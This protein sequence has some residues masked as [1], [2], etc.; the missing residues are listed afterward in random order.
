MLRKLMSAT[1]ALTFVLAGLTAVS[2]ALA[3]EDTNSSVGTRVSADSRSSYVPVGKTLAGEMVFAYAGGQEGNYYLKSY[4]V[5]PTGSIS[6]PITIATN[7][8]GGFY[9]TPEMMWADPSG[10]LHVVFGSSTNA[11][12]GWSAKIT[13]VSSQDGQ[14][15]T[16]PVQL[17]Q[18]AS[19][20]CS[21]GENRCG[22]YGS[23]LT[24]TGSGNLALIYSVAT[25]AGVGEIYVAT[26]ASGKAWAS[27]SKLTTSSNIL[28]NPYLVSTGKGLLATWEEQS[29][30]PRIMSA[31][32]TSTS[33][34]SWTA[35]QQRVQSPTIQTWK[36]MQV[37]ATKFASVYRDSNDDIL[38]MQVFDSTTRRF[39]SAQEIST[40][41][42][43]LGG[44]DPLH[45]QYVA[46][47][48]ALV[49]M[50]G[51]GLSNPTVANYV[52]FR[53]GV[54][55]S[56]RLNPDLAVPN[57]SRQA[58]QGA[59][60]DKSGHLTIVWIHTSDGNESKM[61]VSQIFRGNRSDADVT[62]PDQIPYGYL[63]G[64][65][66]DGDVYMT[67]F[68][69]AT[70]SAKVRLRSDAPAIE[71]SVLASGSPKVGKSLT[72]KLPK[73]TASVSGQKWLNSYQ[74]YSC[75]YRV[76]EVASIPT[77]NCVTIAGATAAT[78]K[79][80]ATDKGK[81][82]QVKLSVKSDNA[83]QVQFSASTLVVK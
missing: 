55:T 57:G 50:R 38:K 62:M 32:S 79:A 51:A 16:T 40:G 47:Q 13:H 77:E 12:N 5:S 49:F 56:H 39:G 6:E 3:W 54:A 35:P 43:S 8:I 36:L 78:Y 66:T 68:W 73:I 23:R 2:P 64:F 19:A 80:K 48:S 11:G 72:A 37:G 4:R 61:Y 24:G 83:T 10:E 21:F 67:N 33:P 18:G 75:Q 82:L 71:T 63:V 9:L 20:E 28:G 30:I 42:G 31:Y 76:T 74:W 45:T 26:K 25:A 22:L 65:S 69:M 14:S 17:F 53:N 70:I 1:I 29:Q 59:T 58:P 81:F 46:G 15:W 44:S 60:M 34:K 52:I 27:S 41:G 7:D